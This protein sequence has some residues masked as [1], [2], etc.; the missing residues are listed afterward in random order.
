MLGREDQ[1]LHQLNEQGARHPEQLL[2]LLERGA[3]LNEQGARHPEQRL[4]LLE[5]CAHLPGRCGVPV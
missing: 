4:Q 3:Q 1:L 5:R 2:Q